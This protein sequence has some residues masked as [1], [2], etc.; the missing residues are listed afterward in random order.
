MGKSWG[1]LL[2]IAACYDPRVQAGVPCAADG[3]CPAGMT[4][5]TGACTSQ[6][7][8]ARA[9]DAEADARR[10][11]ARLADAPAGFAV[12]INIDG[13]AYDGVDYPGAWAA[14]PGAGGICD[15]AAFA[16]PTA[17][18][19]GTQDSPLF[20]GQMFNSTLTCHVAGVPAGTYLVTLL[21]AELRLG[22]SPCVV[23]VGT[24]RVFDIAIEGA[25]V[26]SG[27]DMTQYGSGCAADGGTGHAYSLSYMV[28]VS[29]GS[30]D[31]VETAS[32]GMAALNAVEAVAQ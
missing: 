29:D 28:D 1:S 5:V 14:D 20:V 7:V 26:A 24:D 25:T 9:L 18:V 32:T 22:G 13:S 4:C 15:G 8:D 3:A 23:P 16:S 12:R 19:N 21:F 31:I 30:L 6:V 10:P 11:D 27:F 2:V 17:T